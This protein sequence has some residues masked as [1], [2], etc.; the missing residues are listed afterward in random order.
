MAY[1]AQGY[2]YVIERFGNLVWR[3]VQVVGWLEFQRTAVR[4]TGP[5]T[6]GHLSHD[7]L[8]PTLYAEEYG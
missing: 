6:L 1:G 8:L 7:N 5:D 3:V 4:A 2:S